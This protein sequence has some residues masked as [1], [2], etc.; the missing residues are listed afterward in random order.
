MNGKEIREG[1][2]TETVKAL[3]LINGGGAVALLTFAAAVLN[4]KD[5]L[6]S[7]LRAI[8]SEILQM[9]PEPA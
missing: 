7:L 8:L 1:I 9:N 2:D 6:G 5:E 3:L 4:R